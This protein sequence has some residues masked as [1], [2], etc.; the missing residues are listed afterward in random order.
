MIENKLNLTFYKGT[1][2]YSDGEIEN[3]ILQAIQEENDIQKILMSHNEWP[4]L[5]HLSPI[6]E[7][8]LEWYDFNA[9]GTVLEIGSGCGA[10]TGLLCKKTKRVVGIDLS[11]KRSLINATKNQQFN[12]LEIIVG[13]FED[14]H[15]DE[16]FDYVTLIG[17]L[18]YSASYI[19]AP[20]PFETMLQKA[21]S[22]LKPN[23]KLIIA[24]ENK[25]GLKYWAGAA[26]D[27]TGLLFSG[28]QNYNS[29]ETVR[30]FSKGTLNQMLKDAGFQTNA[31][32]Y[33]MPDYKLP[34]EIYSE[35][36]L[37]KP[38]NL[39]NISTA[40]DRDRYK[41]FDEEKTFDALCEDNLFEEFANSFLVISS[42]E[43]TKDN[44]KKTL[45]AKYTRI[46]N[47]KF[48]TVTRIIEENQLKY[49]EKAALTSAAKEHI[50]S[51]KQKA[52]SLDKLYQNIRPCKVVTNGNT[53]Q[54]D[55]FAGTT[56]GAL[57][58][59]DMQTPDNL[60]IHINNCLENIYSFP[61]EQLI[62]FYPSEQFESIF[63]QYKEL[64]NCIAVCG[65]DLDMN[66]DNFIIQNN[67]IYAIDY[68]WVFDF[69]IPVEY[70]KFRTAYLF[71]VKNYNFLADKISIE[72]YLI[73][74]GLRADML[75][76]YIKMEDSF[77]QYVHGENNKYMY[78]L[79]YQ[80]PE[81]DICYLLNRWSDIEGEIVKKNQRI[82]DLLQIVN[83]KA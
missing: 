8:I 62:K 77:M 76:T 30:T 66:F 56:M 82:I 3:H 58:E 11:K 32:Y 49:V 72:D 69:P 78:P 54:F 48:Q 80:K 81:H 16:K 29:A 35:D 17:V 5:Y 36:Y 83:Q 40:Y 27:H 50:Q 70:I 19:N 38:G 53:A 63:G 12:N 18:E 23:G 22:Y 37:P 60:I 2:I 65:A 71:H 28:I 59:K 64:E 61:A 4:F 47:P 14:V 74:L 73:R 26:E 13:N 68:E 31:F 10:I 21:K 9:D 44:L 45:Y 43:E 42:L 34:S 33:P 20:H 51:F 6:R 46:R 24:I 67:N 75:E 15:L 25:Y 7:N 52:Q 39:R 41:L 57:L 1:D 79:R 55:Y